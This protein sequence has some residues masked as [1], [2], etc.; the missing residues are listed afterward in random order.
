MRPVQGSI[1][2]FVP[3]PTERQHVAQGQQA[4]LVGPG[5]FLAAALSDSYRV[6]TKG[7]V[8]DVGP[9]QYRRYIHP[10]PDGWLRPVVGSL[11][12][13]LIRVPGPC[14][15]QVTVEERRLV[16]RVRV[17]GNS[18]L[19]ALRAY[20]DVQV[21]GGGITAESLCPD[22]SGSVRPKAARQVESVASR[23]EAQDPAT[24]V[25]AVQPVARIHP[26]RSRVAGSIERTAA[27]SDV[28]CAAVANSRNIA[29]SRSLGSTL[30]GRAS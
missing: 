13:C 4:E 27:G 3:P 19:H 24:S 6:P 8:R 15:G 10:G 18:L 20:G 11:L 2:K 28:C 7:V 1:T 14:S 21:P 23:P 29:W 12:R 9:G 22:P 26:T 17:A 5:V 25:D 16:V 30:N